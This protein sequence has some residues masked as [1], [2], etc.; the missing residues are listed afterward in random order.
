MV[1]FAGE[2][3]AIRKANTLHFA[4]TH[5]R[6]ISHKR[7]YTIQTTKSVTLLRKSQLNIGFA[8]DNPEATKGAISRIVSAIRCIRS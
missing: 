1:T 2:R 8:Y 5:K 4:I 3:R 7:I 6:Y